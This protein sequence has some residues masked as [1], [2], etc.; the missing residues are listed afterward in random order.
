MHTQPIP[1]EK[2]SIL[3]RALE[4]VGFTAKKPEAATPEYDNRYTG[5]VFPYSGEVNRGPFILDNPGQPLDARLDMGGNLY[6]FQGDDIVGSGKMV[7]MTYIRPIDPL[8]E[9][10]YMR[11]SIKLASGK[12]LHLV[13][14]KKYDEAKDR[15][16]LQLRLDN[17]P[18]HLGL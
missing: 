14:W 2:A 16:F 5:A 9:P 7:K 6:L 15:E 10:P 3:R 1:V 4:G 8:H 18:K 17:K 13:A 11:G 12:V